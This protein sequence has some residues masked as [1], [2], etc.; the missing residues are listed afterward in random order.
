MIY[1]NV[2]HHKETWDISFSDTQ[3]PSNSK[4]PNPAKNTLKSNNLESP[5]NLS[6]ITNEQAAALKI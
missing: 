5:E 3:A 1:L 2:V 4:F 6:N